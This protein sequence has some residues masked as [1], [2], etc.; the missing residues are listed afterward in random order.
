MSRR[1]DVDHVGQQ[2]GVVARRQLVPEQV[3]LVEP[4]PPPGGVGLQVSLPMTTTCGSSNKPHSI[5]G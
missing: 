3:P 5:E 2:E 1:E 4:D